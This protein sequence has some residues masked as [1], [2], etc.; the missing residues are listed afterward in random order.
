MQINCM[1]MDNEYSEWVNEMELIYEY[2]YVS[3]ILW[4]VCG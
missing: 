3:P 4:C 2:D 1:K